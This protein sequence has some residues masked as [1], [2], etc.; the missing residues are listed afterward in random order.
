MSFLKRITRNRYLLI[1]DFCFIFISY[2]LT[3]GLV[4]QQQYFFEIVIR[5]WAFFAISAAVFLGMMH[6]FGCYRVYWIYAGTKDYGRAVAACLLAGLVT[7]LLCEVYSD[8]GFYLKANILAS[9]MMTV[10]MIGLRMAV[11]VLG[12]LVCVSLCEEQRRTQSGRLKNV[13]IIGA[14]RLGVTLA[15]DISYNEDMNYHILGF[16]DDDPAKLN[17]I[18]A[19]VRVLGTTA[20]IQK[21]C[22]DLKPDEL[23]IAV[24]S[25]S[26]Q[27]R[28]RMIQLCG[29][30][31]CK[32]KIL[33]GLADS[34]KSRNSVS[35]IREVEV[36][37]LL[38]REP[39]QLDNR[40][41]MRDIRG[42]VVMV[43][44]G[45]G[46]IGS[47]LCRQVMRF[48]PQKLIILD[49]YENNAFEL[50]NEL[51]DSFPGYDIEVVIASVRDRK[52]MEKVFEQYR[53]Y[54]VFHAAAHKHVPLM[55]A[56][57]MEAVN[58]N[59]FGTYYTAC[60]ASKYGTKRFIL[61]STDKAVNP[62]S[63]MGAT[64]RICEMI[65]QSMQTVSKTEFVAVRFGNVLNSNGSVVPLFKR[66]IKNGGPVT[67]THP[68]ITRFFMTIPEAA[69]LVLQA[70]AFAQGG[71]IFVLDMG[72]P[73]KIYDLA[74]NLIRLSGLR[75]GVDINIEITGLRPGEKLYEELLMNEEG[76]KKTSHDKI[77]IGTPFFN[78]INK[79][80]ENLALLKSAVA[81]QNNEIVKNAI[82][83]VVPTYIRKIEEVSIQTEEVE[84]SVKE[85]VMEKKAAGQQL[86]AI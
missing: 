38:K 57:A 67:V 72:E 59:V 3:V 54:L 81:S 14:G 63:V 61:I 6:V 4:Y 21:L 46:S 71:E 69:Q 29:E 85:K 62:T 7:D 58:N 19:G 28:K 77:F 12:K 80:K 56:N 44:G 23:I 10:S 76:L 64:K 39:I 65:V 45:G 53:P 78:D 20:E 82:A 66:Q 49:I 37:D 68:E 24:S 18:I 5:N 84:N 32:L 2:L 41:I 42:K 9:G 31:D 43:T 70:A 55:E 8:G 15:K 60:C 79:L 11:R 26:V 74:K 30:T 47:E 40:A 48:F 73:V 52:R 35:Y 27:A 16:V 22:N 33:P 34:L 75:L 36:E 1:G 17:A 86:A 13:L 51:K 50:E 83:Q 25:A